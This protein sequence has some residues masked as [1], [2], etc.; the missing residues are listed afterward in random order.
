[1]S[2]APELRIATASP[3]TAGDIRYY[4]RLAEGTIHDAKSLWR[5]HHCIPYFVNGRGADIALRQFLVASVRTEG[6]AYLVD[7]IEKTCIY[8]QGGRDYICPDLLWNYKNKPGESCVHMK[9][10]MRKERQYV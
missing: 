5:L 4:T 7:L 3:M 8:R 2:A 1:M 10:A 9:A 6:L